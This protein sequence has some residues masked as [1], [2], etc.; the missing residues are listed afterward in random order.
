MDKN[1]KMVLWFEQTA[2]QSLISVK[3]LDTF[4]LVG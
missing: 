1:W 4:V 3:I 2:L